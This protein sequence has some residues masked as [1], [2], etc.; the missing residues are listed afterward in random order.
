MLRDIIPEMD[1]ELINE[2]ARLAG[3]RSF[4]ALA[5]PDCR[6]SG[7]LPLANLPRNRRCRPELDHGPPGHSS[8]R[9]LAWPRLVGGYGRGP[10]PLLTAVGMGSPA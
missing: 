9:V 7:G 5:A 2:S 10:G 8:N 1:M 4:P 6:L 3:N